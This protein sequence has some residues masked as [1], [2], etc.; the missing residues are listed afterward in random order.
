MNMH[1][2]SSTGY[3]FGHVDWTG[4]T[5]NKQPVV[6]KTRHGDSFRGTGWLPFD[7][8]AE[9]KRLEGHVPHVEH[10][11][12]P[13][14]IYGHQNTFDVLGDIDA[15]IKHWEAASALKDPKGKGRKYP[16]NKPV[17]ANGVISF[18]RERMDDWDD[19]RDK[20]VEWLKKK[21]G[22]ALRCVVEHR[23]DESHPHIH[24]YCIARF[25]VD[26]E[27]KP[28]VD[29]FD[30]IHQGYAARN[31]ERRRNAKEKGDWSAGGARTISS[32]TKAMEDWQE[33]LHHEVSRYFGLARKGPG[34]ERTPHK[35]AM[36]LNRQRK[37]LAAELQEVDREKEEAKRL[38]R[39]QK[40]A[41]AKAQA[42]LFTAEE[43]RRQAEEAAA[44]LEAD[45]RMFE[46]EKL[47]MQKK[48]ER[49]MAVFEHDKKV[50]AE[51]VAKMMSNAQQHVQEAIMRDK[52]AEEKRDYAI[53][54][55]TWVGNQSGGKIAFV[56]KELD[57]ARD[58]IVEQQQQIDDL[59]ARVDKLTDEVDE[60]KRDLMSVLRAIGKAAAAPFRAIY[61][62]Y[63]GKGGDGQ[64]TDAPAPKRVK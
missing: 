38:A 48:H 52:Q 18:P 4:R 45:R 24:W 25:G 22:D 27:G 5:R 47:R 2:D 26:S 7:L 59:K 63:F 43:M 60:V 57:T 14:Y 54:L 3:Q 21:Y 19:Y 58:V 30:T 55:L 62:K 17:M 23:D 40:E 33:E 51:A 10:P 15:W 1:D 12:D 13:I 50:A 31:A 34:V 56:K 16:V 41:H 29:D 39:E 49:E 61:E 36:N 28:W 11:Q 46:L 9:A 37:K 32:F 20:C 42:E 64:L 6:F 44:Q 35:V 53:N 8:L